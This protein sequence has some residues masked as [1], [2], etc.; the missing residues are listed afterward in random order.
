MLVLAVAASVSARS[1]SRI[2]NRAF[3]PIA[4]SRVSA[5]I[6]P[7]PISRTR[8][9]TSTDNPASGKPSVN[10]NLPAGRHSVRWFNPRTGQW[11]D[12]E[13]LDGGAQRKLTAPAPQRTSAGDWVL[14]ISRR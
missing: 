7:G 14:L 11:T 13:A 3:G 4:T 2:V 12:G 9:A 5:G 10:I 1:I 8:P 6:G